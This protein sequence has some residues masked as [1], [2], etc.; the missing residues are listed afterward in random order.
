MHT[1][2]WK[3][4]QKGTLTVENDASCVTTIVVV[5]K[6]KVDAKAEEGF[7]K[8]V[9]RACTTDTHITRKLCSQ[10]KETVK[11]KK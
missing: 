11:E 6:P 5:R 3:F 7:A 2:Q 1:V 10:K 4:K 8:V 9:E